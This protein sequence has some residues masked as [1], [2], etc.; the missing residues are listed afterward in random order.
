[1]KSYDDLERF[2][3]KTHTNHIEFKDMSEQVLN[4]D[5]TNWT[6]IK[7][8]LNE[9]AGSVLNNSQLINR[10]APQ[11]VAADTFISSPGENV[12]VISQLAVQSFVPA[13]PA[14]S[15]RIGA[16]LLDSIS[17]SLQPAAE[18]APVDEPEV[19]VSKTQ[20][21]EAAPLRAM[22][23]AQQTAVSGSSLLAQLSATPP[24]A[25]QQPAASEPPAVEPQPV[26]Q[27]PPAQAAQPAVAHAFIPPR[28]PA[29]EA[30][31]TVSYKQL[32]STAAASAPA[33]LPKDMLLHPLLEK[34]ASCR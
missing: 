24:A 11:P 18:P 15:S 34:I 6:V 23:M 7:Q 20:P 28:S 22:P 29:A 13:T 32:F 26:F 19:V 9:G 25:A 4:S 16:S 31:A 5:T 30:P 3:Q 10:P 33:A 8:L 27:A 2:K 12:P 14:A 17:A 21:A 1:M